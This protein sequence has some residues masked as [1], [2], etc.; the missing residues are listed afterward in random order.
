MHPRGA[1][2]W[3]KSED[4]GFGPSLLQPFSNAKLW[5]NLAIRRIA[6]NLRRLHEIIT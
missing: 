1:L 4:A 5:A 2:A 6:G 3:L